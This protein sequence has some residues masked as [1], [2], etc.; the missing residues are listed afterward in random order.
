MLGDH[1][2]LVGSPDCEIP[3]SYNHVPLM[4]YGKGIK[5][6]IRQEPGGQTDVAPTLLGLLNMS[7]TQND[8]GINLLTEQRPYVYLN[9]EKPD[10]PLNKNDAFQKVQKR[11]VQ[12]KR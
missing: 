3:Q 10:V 8:F 1:G 9:P 7:Y 5:P 12:E 2:K 4:I 11:R 6:E